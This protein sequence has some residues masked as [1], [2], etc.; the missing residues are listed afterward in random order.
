MEK[1]RGKKNGCKIKATE[2]PKRKREK[3]S[4]SQN[5]SICYTSLSKRIANNVNGQWRKGKDEKLKWTYLKKARTGK[6]ATYKESHC[7]QK[8]M[9]QN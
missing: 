1:Y 6:E 9:T 2:I 7:T 8:L 3:Y 4:K 5:K